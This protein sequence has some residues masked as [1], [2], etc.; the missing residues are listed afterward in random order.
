MKWFDERFV[1]IQNKIKDCELSCV[2]FDETGFEAYSFRVQCE[3]L[4]SRKFSQSLSIYLDDQRL[5][6]QK[7]DDNEFGHF[8]LGFKWLQIT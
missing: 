1:K 6:N 5:K 7:N 8:A 3:A 4:C 2:R